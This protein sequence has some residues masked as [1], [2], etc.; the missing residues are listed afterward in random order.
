LIT[1]RFF[2]VAKIEHRLNIVGFVKNN[3][4]MFVDVLFLYYPAANKQTNAPP[5][6]WL[7]PW[8]PLQASYYLFSV[9]AMLAARQQLDCARPPAAQRVLPKLVLM[10]SSF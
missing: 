8:T 9:M 7:Q 5:K 3:Q 4:Q 2:F 1:I 10:L 6:A